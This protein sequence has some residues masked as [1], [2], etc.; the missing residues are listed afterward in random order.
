MLSGSLLSALQVSN[1][2]TEDIE[3]CTVSSQAPIPAWRSL[4][5]MPEK[6]GRR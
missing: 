5:L 4:L 6:F 3:Q 2:L 1:G